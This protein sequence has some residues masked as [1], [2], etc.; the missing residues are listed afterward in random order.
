MIAHE[1]EDVMDEIRRSAEHSKQH[2]DA[3]LGDDYARKMYDADVLLRAQLLNIDLTKNDIDR[4]SRRNIE[5]SIRDVMAD[6][7]HD[8]KINPDKLTEADI[9]KMDLSPEEKDE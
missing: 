7:A 3:L 2:H 1:L 9:K 4:D 6:I 8:P 5:K